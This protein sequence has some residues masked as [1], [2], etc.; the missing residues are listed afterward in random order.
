VLIKL[1]VT[2]FINVPVPVPV[3]VFTCN[4][5]IPFNICGGAVDCGRRE[6]SYLFTASMITVQIIGKLSQQTIF[7]E[8][9]TVNFKDFHH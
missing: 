3:A 4:I 9:F 5:A 7:T 8:Y 2:A 6:E 1:P